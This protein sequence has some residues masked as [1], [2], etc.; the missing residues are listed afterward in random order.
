MLNLRTKVAVAVVIVA[1]LGC[2]REQSREPIVRIATQPPEEAGEPVVKP[3][4]SE[5]LPGDW[6]VVSNNGDG[7]MLEKLDDEDAWIWITLES[8]YSGVDIPE[9]VRIHRK[10]LADSPAGTYIDNGHVETASYGTGTWSWGSYDGE[11]EEEG[12]NDLF[13]FLAIPQRDRVLSLRYVFPL[14]GGAGFDDRLA[15][16]VAVA[17]GLTGNS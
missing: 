12:Q 1:L 11:G 17:D 10:T 15:E 9:S 14:E 7:M 5:G 2:G 3:D 16:L 4:G 6:Y 8:T 13:L